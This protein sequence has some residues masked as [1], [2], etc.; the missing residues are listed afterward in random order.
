MT[1]SAWDK[2]ATTARLPR[3]SFANVST[4][5]ETFYVHSANPVIR[6]VN[7][8]NKL[9]KTKSRRPTVPPF[10]LVNFTTKIISI[11]VRTLRLHE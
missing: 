4:F 9:D 6:S 10:T 2:F 3:S 1:V 7:G 8:I 11:Y 5:Q